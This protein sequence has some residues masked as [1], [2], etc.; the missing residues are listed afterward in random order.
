MKAFID[1]ST[2]AKK[3]KDE[4]GRDE[5]LEI[6]KK[7]DEIVISSVTYIELICLIRR[8]LED[9]NKNFSIFKKLKKEIDLD[10]RCFHTISIDENLKNIACELRLKYTLKSLNLIQI[11]SAKISESGITLTSDKHFYKVACQEL[12]NVQLI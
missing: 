3:Y 8:Y 1:T 7:V 9:F 6:L 5:F 12:K 2:L 4:P 11:S 10:F